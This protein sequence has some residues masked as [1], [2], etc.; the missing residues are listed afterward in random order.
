M[1]EY[2]VGGVPHFVFMD[3]NNE[4]LAAAVGRLPRK[5]LEGA[6]DAI[7]VGLASGA[8]V[9]LFATDRVPLPAGTWE[10][11]PALWMVFVCV[12]FVCCCHACVC[13]Q[14]VCAGRGPR[15]A[16]HEGRW[17]GV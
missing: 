16:L 1:A 8:G 6:W 7:G 2:G 14:R 12:T 15:A 9:C 5:V 10:G 17:G 4:P 11:D 13:R 3:G